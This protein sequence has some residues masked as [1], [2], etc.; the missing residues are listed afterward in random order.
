VKGNREKMWY[1]LAKFNP[2][3]R[4]TRGTKLDL[5]YLISEDFTIDQTNVMQM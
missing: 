4:K 3:D 1:F 5:E 2:K